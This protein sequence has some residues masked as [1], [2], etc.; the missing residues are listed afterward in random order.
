MFVSDDGERLET[1]GRYVSKFYDDTKVETIYL[2]FAQPDYLTQLTNSNTY[3]TAT[4]RYKDKTLQQVGVQYRGFSS[5]GGPKPSLD[6]DLEWMIDG[7][8]LNGYDQLKLNSA[9]ED[10][11][12][13]REVIYANLAR[14]NI[15]IAKGSFVKLVINGKNYGI[16]SNIQKLDKSHVKEWFLDKDA[17]RWRAEG[18]NKGQNGFG[19]G[20]ST[21]NDLGPDGSSYEAAY[22]LKFSALVDPWQDLANAA[23]TLGV[24]SPEFLAEE[25]GKYMDI[26]AT[27]WYLATENLFLDDDSYWSKGGMDYYIYFDIATQR[28]VPIEYDGNSVL[29]PYFSSI[30]PLSFLNRPATYPLLNKLLP[31]P[32]FK[33]RYLAHY[34]TLLEEALEPTMVQA[35]LDQ[36]FTLID[37]HMAE[38]NQARRFTYNE[39]LAGFT[40]LKNFIPQL[41]NRMKN[42]MNINHTPVTINSVIDSVAGQV[43]VRPR[44]D[45]NVDVRATVSGVAAKNLNLYYGSGLMGSFKKVAMTNNGNGQFSGV[46]PP[47]PKGEYVR[48]YVEAI[49]NDAV[50]TA[51]YSPKGAEHDVYI[52]QV[53]A[54]VAAASPVVINELMPS[55]V[56]TAVDELG[57]Y[58]DWIELYNNSNQPVDLT[59]WHLTDEDTK[60]DRWAFPAGTIIP[61]NDTLII[62]ADDQQ[63]LTSGLHT[64]FK[65]SAS[66]ETLYLVNPA[67]AF[68]DQVTFTNAQTDF[69]YA[70]RPN[71]QGNFVWTNASSFDKTNQ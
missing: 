12:A 15:P 28:I 27:L 33:Q 35:K 62:W 22:D 18:T 7:Q 70:R 11:S 50:N 6:I 64:N 51:S 40:E 53:Q 71:G 16:Y 65:L 38:T 47:F 61:A 45:Q 68:A 63:T 69:S 29:R 23:H 66:G 34:R 17:T 52:Y 20:V 37:P 8:D 44:D 14:K 1:G 30:L 41:H 59:G 5:R 48:Y 60:L 56:T 43:S 24:I 4:L 67:K 19:L 36:Y 46:I 39:F 13:M 9:A 10:P 25:L 57:N 42:D 21:L 58:G 55:N 32:E 54:A 26:D 2:D 3:T 49:A 31:I